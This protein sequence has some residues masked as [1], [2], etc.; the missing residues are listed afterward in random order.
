[1]EL[2]NSLEAAFVTERLY[3]WCFT[4]N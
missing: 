4:C 1:M 3:I 2:C